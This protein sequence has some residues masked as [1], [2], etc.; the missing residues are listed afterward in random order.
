[1][2]THFESIHIT[3]VPSYQSMY[4]PG[5][6][7]L[8]AAGQL[9]FHNP[10]VAILI[11]TALMC[12]ALTWMLQAWLP[13]NWALLGGFIAVIRLGVFSYW[14][15]TYHAAGS[16][17]A[18]GGALVLG[19]LPRLMKTP[20]LRYAILMGTGISILALTRPYEGVLLCLPVGVALIRWMLK[21]KNRPPAAVLA[22]YAAVPLALIVATVAWLGYYDLKAFGKVTTLPYTV[23]RS[24]YGIA[25]YYVWQDAR[26]EPHYRHAVMRSFY[27]KGELDFFKQIH[28]PTGFVPYTLE[29]GGLIL[30]FYAGFTFL[31]PLIMLRRVCLDRRVR[32]LVACGLVLMAGMVIEIYVLPHYVAP[33][34]CAFYAIGLQA[35]RHLRLWRPEGKPVGV[36][37]VRWTVFSCVALAA[38][39]VFAQPLHLVPAEWPPSN[40]NFTWFGPE[41]Y[42]VERA[43]IDHQLEQLPGRHLVFVR[44]SDDH[45]VFD[46]WIY[47]PA[48]FATAKVLWAWDMGPAENPALSKYYP[49]RTAW[50]AEPDTI[51]ARVLPYPE[52]AEQ[53][54]GEAAGQQISANRTAANGEEPKP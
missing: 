53:P 45:P 51:P 41:H 27:H 8:L 40:W 19:A 47:N 22:R 4:F 9:L 2:W 17:A 12:A 31:I 21:G 49:N 7:L 35:M 26:P 46:E 14:T 52:A 3:M 18:L 16:L 38:L 28:Q 50:L 30:L 20:R 34:A 1:M 10:W 29:K 33:F 42:G 15:N 25:P 24:E 36:T 37:I 39:R 13:A 5:Q 48:D 44:Y 54:P 23:D 32:F 43:R 6:G 11:S